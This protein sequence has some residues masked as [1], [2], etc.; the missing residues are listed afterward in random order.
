M[1]PFDVLVT[2]IGWANGGK[3][4]PVLIFKCVGEYVLIFRITSQFEVKSEA[5][6]SRY[7]K[8]NDWKQAGLDKQSYVDIGSLHRAK[9][10][11]FSNAPGI[12]RLTES[13]KK[14]L[15][16]FLTQNEV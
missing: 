7:F 9:E 12:G 2:Y 14:R 6:R 15:I 13:D 11:V 16:E 5:I 10:T 4:R 8:I 3:R 1:K